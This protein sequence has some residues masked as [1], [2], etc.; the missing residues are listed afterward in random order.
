MNKSEEVVE[1]FISV[2][3]EV[4]GNW[5]DKPDHVQQKMLEAEKEIKKN[6]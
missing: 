3:D 1:Y 5:R 4:S 6:E 2:L